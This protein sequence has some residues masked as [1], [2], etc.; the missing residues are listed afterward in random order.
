MCFYLLD[1]FLVVTKRLRLYTIKKG[2]GLHGLITSLKFANTKC[3]N[4]H[5]FIVR[6]RVITNH[7]IKK[8]KALGKFLQ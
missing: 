8:I 1:V 6:G 2:Y 7:V 5:L 3:D 4:F